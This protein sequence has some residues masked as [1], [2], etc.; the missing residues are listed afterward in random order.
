M[1]IIKFR[2]GVLYFI[3]CPYKIFLNILKHCD[4]FMHSEQW[5]PAIACFGSSRTA[6]T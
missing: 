1:K 3:C 2:F 4:Y 6:G 5:A